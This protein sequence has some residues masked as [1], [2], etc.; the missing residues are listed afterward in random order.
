M[1]ITV[2]QKRESRYS[3]VSDRS[4]ESNESQEF[5]QSEAQKVKNAPLSKFRKGEKE[6][7]SHKV[8]SDRNS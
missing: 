3:H 6:R 7:T 8:S 4:S 5:L 2:K 1:N